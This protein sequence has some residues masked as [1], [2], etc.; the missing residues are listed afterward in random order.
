MRLA[1]A[2]AAD[3]VFIFLVLLIGRFVITM[4]QNF[5]RDWRPHGVVLVIAELIYTVTDPPLVLLRRVIPPIRLGGISLD[6]GFILLFFL[7][8]IVLS[9]LRN[10]ATA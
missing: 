4:I 7:T 10:L 1:W 3:V 9:L 2:I 8:G 6:L 5:A